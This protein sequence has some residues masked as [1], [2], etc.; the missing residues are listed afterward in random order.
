MLLYFKYAHFWAY[1]YEYKIRHYIFISE[2]LDSYW[3]KIMHYFSHHFIR[4]NCYYIYKIWCR[5]C[6]YVHIF[7]TDRFYNQLQLFFDSNKTD[8]FDATSVEIMTHPLFY[9]SC[10]I[11]AILHTYN[12]ASFS[13]EVCMVQFPRGI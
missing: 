9:T 7:K 5:Y 8:D 4:I 1:C 6:T 11:D 10:I 2:G 13:Q 3:K 12:V